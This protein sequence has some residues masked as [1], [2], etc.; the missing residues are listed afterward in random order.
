MRVMWM[1][2]LR[3]DKKILTTDVEALF[4]DYEARL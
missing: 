3:G 2:W 4:K 1:N